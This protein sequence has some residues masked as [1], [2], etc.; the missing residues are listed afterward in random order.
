MF[1]IMIMIKIKRRYIKH[2]RKKTAF[3]TFYETTNFND[4]LI[5]KRIKI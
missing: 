3:L 2:S 5:K 1:K 4:P